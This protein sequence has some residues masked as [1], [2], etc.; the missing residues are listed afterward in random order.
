MCLYIYIYILMQLN[1]NNTHFQ[2]HTLI[3]NQKKNVILCVCVNTVYI[4]KSLIIILYNFIFPFYN[5][6]VLET[7]FRF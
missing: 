5:V 7:V 2:M 6:Y 1:N 3:I 4:L